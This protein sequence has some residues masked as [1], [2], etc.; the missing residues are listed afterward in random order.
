MT[1]TFSKP[2]LIRI[3]VRWHSSNSQMLFSFCFQYRFILFFVHVSLGLS[4]KQYKWLNELDF[5]NWRLWIQNV[6]QNCYCLLTF[7]WCNTYIDRIQEISQ[8][9]SM[10]ILPTKILKVTV[11]K[12]YFIFSEF[13]FFSNNRH[14][15]IAWKIRYEMSEINRRNWLFFRQTL[16][17]IEFVHNTV[18]SVKNA[19][20]QYMEIGIF[21]LIYYERLQKALNEFTENFVR[22]KIN[23]RRRRNKLMR[24]KLTRKNNVRREREGIK[25]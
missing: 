25:Q 7:A 5:M 24:T 10:K 9:W 1:F 11:F 8:K 4:N 23:N 14:Q 2:V 20:I 3:M 16:E 22:N 12:L 21:C 18:I 17:T 15:S 13:F 19:V 6:Y